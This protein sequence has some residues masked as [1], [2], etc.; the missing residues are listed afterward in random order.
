MTLRLER[1][2]PWI[3]VGGVFI[4]LWLAITTVLYAPWWGVALHVIAIAPP[5]VLVGRWAREQPRRCAWLPLLGVA[6][7]ATLNAIGIGL[8]GWRMD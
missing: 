4:H 2:G 5:A 6:I 8:L 3:G 7:W 1:S